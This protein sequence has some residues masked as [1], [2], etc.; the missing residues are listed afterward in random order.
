[1]KCI[2]GNHPTSDFVS[3]HPSFFSLSPPIDLKFSEKQLFEEF[4]T[5][6]DDSM[7]YSIIIGHDVWIGANVSILDGVTIGNGAIIA[8]NALVNKDVDPYTI[9]G[10]VPAKII[11]K[12]FKE[13]D[14]EFLNTLAWWN[15]PISWISENA[16]FF[17][18][19]E[20]L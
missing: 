9:V 20:K 3:T 6:K 11:K 14:I 15:K 2:F 13:E 1:V 18:N 17:D 8:A 12:R 16:K 19:I 10:G 5:P 4:S 7:K